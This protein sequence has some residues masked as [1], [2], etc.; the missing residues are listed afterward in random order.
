MKKLEFLLLVFLAGCSPS[1]TA[2]QTAIAST[3]KA[4][5]IPT[6]TPTLEPT[7]TPIPTINFSKNVTPTYQLPEILTTA[8]DFSN[9]R[10]CNI[11]KCKQSFYQIL[12]ATG[13]G[14]YNFDV[15]DPDIIV[16]L[17]TDSD[18]IVSYTLIFSDE[19]KLNNQDLYL[20]YSF[21]Q[22]INP[23]IKIDEGIQ[24]FIEGNIE[25]SIIENCTTNPYEFGSF[26]I[27]VSDHVVTVGNKCD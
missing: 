11:Y 18:N 24:T 16:E 25:N 12:K 6:S 9:T 23:N 21:L 4:L 8:K 22:S 26:K 10:F 19:Q 7:N 15:T 14:D 5:P 2:I 20:I 27:W 3:Q 17:I 13:Q 1:E